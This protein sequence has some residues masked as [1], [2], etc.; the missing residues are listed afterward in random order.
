M[1]AAAPQRSRSSLLAVVV[2]L[3]GLYGYAALDSYSAMIDGHRVFWL[4]D[5][6]MISMRYARNLA[7]EG[8]LVWNPGGERVEG[9]SNLGWVLVMAAVHTLPLPK[10]LTSAGMLALNLGMAAWILVLTQRLAGRLAPLA[11]VAPL[12]ALVALT[13]SAD[14]ARFCVMGLETIPATALFLWLV[15]R[16]LAEAASGRSLALTYFA[17]G[18]LGVLRVDGLFLSGLVV[19]LALLLG[20]KPRRLA[21][22]APWALVLPA[23]VTT[24]RLVYY[25]Y[26]LPNTY[27]LKVTGWDLASRLAAGAVY[28]EGFFKSYGL[29]W[30][31]SAGGAYASRDRRFQALWLIG[32]PLVAYGVWVGGD[33]FHGLRFLAPWLPVL[34]LLGFLAPGY[35]GWPERSWRHLSVIGTL[36]VL[37][38]ATTGYRFGE[39]PSP[40]AGFVRAGLFLG[41]VTGP[42]TSM[43]HLWAGTIPYFAE[44]PSIDL[45]GKCDARIAH[46]AAQPGLSKPGHNKFDFA[47]SLALEP[48]LVIHAVHPSYLWAPASV[49]EL[50][51]TEDA[52]LARLYLDSGFQAR[53]AP[54]VAFVSGVPVFVA[55]GAADRGRLMTGRCA[56]VGA[57]TL[58]ALG[59]REACWPEAPGP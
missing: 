34:L 41:R 14:L 5:D 40:E 13:L 25:G 6:M 37:V 48:D 49:R 17:A 20:E 55:E 54:R 28:T 15:L 22:L 42:G 19:L 27:Y 51:S 3:L 44:R 21:A 53:Y 10:T 7:H 32:V 50:A 59:M 47:Y 43:A 36:G 9:Y 18:A 33:S 12:V 31:V 39:G 46:M 58:V 35:A 29:V 4:Q 38:W 1:S 45:L 52:Y 2:L 26:P 24:F 56:P 30:L 16:V 23:L 8:A 11:K 57:E